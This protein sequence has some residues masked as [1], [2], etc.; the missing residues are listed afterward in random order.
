[1]VDKMKSL[2]N[3]YSLINFI[4]PWDICCKSQCENTVKTQWKN[5]ESC[6]KEKWWFLLLVPPW[7]FYKTFFF[8]QTKKEASIETEYVK[9]QYEEDLRK[10]KHQTEEE[11]K[12]LKDQL[13]KRLED[14]I[15]KHTMEIKSV[16]SSVEAERKTLQKVSHPFRHFSVPFFSFFCLPPFLLY[17]FFSSSNIFWASTL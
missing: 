2:K 15:K 10:I 9:Q 7:Q 17:S 6:T 8:L 16:R 14:L 1:M 12:H 13:V 11:K 3:I 4:A 5:T